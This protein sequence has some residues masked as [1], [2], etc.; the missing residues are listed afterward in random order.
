M[1][2]ASFSGDVVL[3]LI[4]FAVV[5][6]CIFEIKVWNFEIKVEPLQ[7]RG[8]VIYIPEGIAIPNGVPAKVQSSDQSVKLLQDNCPRVD[9]E[10]HIALHF[11]KVCIGFCGGVLSN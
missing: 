6:K 4:I 5:S 7:D 11:V 2:H 1:T 3:I 9:Y 10:P 8:G